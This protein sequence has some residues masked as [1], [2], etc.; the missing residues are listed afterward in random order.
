M[1]IKYILSK[2]PRVKE[3]NKIIKENFPQLLVE[4]KPQLY[5][6]AGGDGAMLHAIHKT[7]NNYL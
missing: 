5:L 3:F 1:R 6:V 2:D 7:I 4:K